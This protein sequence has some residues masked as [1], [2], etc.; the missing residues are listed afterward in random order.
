M[1]SSK[2]YTPFNFW[3]FPVPEKKKLTR[4]QTN[5]L[6]KLYIN[7]LFMTGFCLYLKLPTVTQYKI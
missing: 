2:S 3:I 5:E 6:F 7:S 4:Y 1:F